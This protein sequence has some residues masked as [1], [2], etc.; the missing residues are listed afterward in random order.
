MARMRTRFPWVD[1]R[2][3]SI[4][5]VGLLYAWVMAVPFE[6]HILYGLAKLYGV[7][8]NTTMYLALGAHFIG[9]LTSGLFIKRIQ[10]AR[11]MMFHTSLLCL[12]TSGVLCLPASYL[13][14]VVLTATMF[15]TGLCVGAWGFFFKN[16]TMLA[17]RNKTAAQTLVFTNTVLLVLNSIAVHISPYVGLGVGAVLLIVSMR[18]SLLLPKKET[19]HAK[20]NE[21][22]RPTN[23]GKTLA[24]LY[25][26]VA[27]TA[28]EGGLMF[29]TINPFYEHL[30][31]LSCCYWV[32]PYIAAI[33]IVKRLPERTNRF[34]LLYIAIAMG[35]FSLLAFWNLPKNVFGYLMVDTL[36]MGAAGITQLF[37]WGIL[38]HMLSFTDNPARTFGLG[39]SANALGLFIG[40]IYGQLISGSD[41]FMQLMGF[42]ALSVIFVALVL[43]PLLQMFLGKMFRATG[44]PSNK[45]INYQVAEENGIEKECLKSVLTARE[46]EVMTLLLKGYTYKAAAS[47]LNISENT[48]K[49]YVKNIYAKL[50]VQ[51]RTELIQYVNNLGYDNV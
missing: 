33:V 6:G 18:L 8:I 19:A 24:L 3:L 50:E 42:L 9:L 10:M 11:W 47:E 49:T 7:Q 27:V 20:E 44:S 35:G 17:D 36:L 22:T 51:N 34:Y 43:L 45:A 31:S 5:V 30:T 12:I 26:F 4:V 39:L 28:L 29:Q 38:G 14:T 15:V 1:E 21:T 40:G 41:S 48:V 2:R 32:M 37:F 13:W 46:F 16:A 25:A 23:L